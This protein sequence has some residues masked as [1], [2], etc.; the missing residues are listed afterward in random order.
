MKASRGTYFAMFI[1]SNRNSSAQDIF[2]GKTRIQNNIFFI[3]AI[4]ITQ[5]YRE[6][7]SK[8]I[9]F[10]HHKKFSVDASKAVAF[11]R[12]NLN[13]RQKNAKF[14]KLKKAKYCHKLLG[15]HY[16]VKKTF[17]FFTTQTVIILFVCFYVDFL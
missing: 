8:M 9:K 14:E 5:R 13:M 10:V 16:P 15:Y 7:L 11:E 4:N 1:D 3:S 17:P 2:L 12:C 6:W